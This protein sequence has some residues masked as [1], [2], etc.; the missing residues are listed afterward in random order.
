MVEAALP[1]TRARIEQFATTTTGRDRV[2]TLILKEKED[3]QM[4]PNGL[5]DFVH[6][7]SMCVLRTVN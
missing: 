5:Q 7:Q 1:D 6:L 3:E 2:I 4:C